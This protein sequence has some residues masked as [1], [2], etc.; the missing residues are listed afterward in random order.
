MVNWISHLSI[1]NPTQS[2]AI[3]SAASAFLLM[4]S[5]CL[6]VVG[7]VLTWPAWRPADSCRTLFAKLWINES[8]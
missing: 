5:R 1:A 7:M 3:S 6:G 4:M 2:A 8:D